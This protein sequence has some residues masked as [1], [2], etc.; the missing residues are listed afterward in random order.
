MRLTMMTN[1]FKARVTRALA[2]GALAMAAAACSNVDDRLLGVETPDIVTPE[3]A[4]SAAGAQSFYVAALGD[5]HRLVGGDR[6]GSSPLGLN[7]SGGMLAD[8]IFSARSG[9]E[10]MDNR[11]LNPNNFPIDSW[12][13]VGNAWVRNIRALRLIAQ[14]P[15]ATGK[16]AQLGQLHANL[17]YIAVLAAEHYCNGIPLW[18]GLDETL[19][20]TVTM[21]TDQ[22]YAAAI[23]Q[24]DS[25]LTLLGTASANA[26]VRQLALVGKA[27]AL[28]D[29]AKAGSLAGDLQK[30]ADVAKD[31]PTTFVHNTVFSK[32]TSGLGNAIYDWM[33]GTRN[34]GA[35]DKE[36]GNG[37]DYVSARDP[38]LK[39]AACTG[40]VCRGQDGN[41]TPTLTQYPNLDSPVPVATGSSSRRCHR[42]RP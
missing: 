3:N 21:S 30:A 29:M 19:V 33:L 4:A 20:K 28:V 14:F 18:D 25:A 9:T 42:P 17:G 16:E 34:F 8:E 40:S 15:P 12:T 11:A 26:S 22:L 38:R 23:A 13:Q 5:F 1:R 39:V 7:L 41:P 36:G 37:L 35:S 27:R 32:S 31:V 10:H 2:A 6:A 24:F